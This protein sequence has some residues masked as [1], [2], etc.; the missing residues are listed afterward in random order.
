MATLQVIERIHLADKD[1]MNR[2]SGIIAPKILTKPWEDDADL[3]PASA[4][5]SFDIVE[6][7]C[8]TGDLAERVN[9]EGDHV[10]RPG[11]KEPSGAIPPPFR[12]NNQQI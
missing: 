6:G 8:A 1:I 7:V 9:A 11:G 2:R 5:A 4:R 10:F 3:F 12:R